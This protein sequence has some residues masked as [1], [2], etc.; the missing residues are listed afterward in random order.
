MTRPIPLDLCPLICTSS[1]QHLTSCQWKSEGPQRQGPHGILCPVFIIVRCV[2]FPC[3]SCCCLQKLENHVILVCGYLFVTTGT[4]AVHVPS[5]FFPLKP[6]C[7]RETQSVLVRLQGL[8]SLNR[9]LVPGD[10]IV[11]TASQVDAA[12]GSWGRDSSSGDLWVIQ[13]LPLE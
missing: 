12:M 8:T 3:F 13:P 1:W 11:S 7:Q 2:D 9:G 4:Q 5:W 6:F 10:P